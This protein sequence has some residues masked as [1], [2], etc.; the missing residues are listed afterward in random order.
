[1]TSDGHVSAYHNGT[2][3]A[4][5]ADN[6]SPDW[7]A[8]VCQHIGAGAVLS[9]STVALQRS[10]YL[11]IVK[12]SL[13]NISQLTLSDKCDSAAGVQLV[14]RDASCGLSSS[15]VQPFIVG[16]EI[17]PE[18]AWPWAAALLYRGSYQ[19]SASVI[20]NGWL[21]T[22]AHCFFSAFTTQPLTN[23]PH[24]FAVRLGSVLSSGYSRHVQVASV[25]R[26]VLHHDYTLDASTN[27]R[28]NDIA[29]VQLG[30]DLLRPS[31]SSRVS[32]M[33]LAD[34]AH[35]S[36]TTLKTWQC[37]VIG[38]GVSSV[39]GYSESHSLLGR[40]TWYVGG[41]IFYQCFFFLSFFF[42]LSS[43]FAA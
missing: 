16:G 24:Y 15:S 8:G 34:Y 13:Y 17:A 28:Y 6:W 4:V 39:D 22:A 14:C 9:V 35:H 10:F 11:T 36:L 29:L 1:M 27:I 31:A 23:V 20:G 42:L 12:G 5:C 40:P 41:L 38:W 19:C 2:F 32:P 3:Y 37:Y 26:I 7:S 21:V 43:F 18:N 25:K 33:C 30:D